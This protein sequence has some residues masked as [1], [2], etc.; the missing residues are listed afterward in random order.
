MKIIVEKS[1][2]P[3]W[4]DYALLHD[5]WPY[6][7]KNIR[8]AVPCG[9]TMLSYKHWL[10]LHETSVICRSPLWLDY[11][12]L[13][14]PAQDIKKNI[15]SQSL[16]IGLYSPTWQPGYKRKKS[17]CRSPFWLDY[18]LL[19]ADEKLEY[20]K[21]LSQSLLIGLYSPTVK[22]SWD[23]DLCDLSQSL[24]IGLYSPTKSEQPIIK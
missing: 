16:L 7:S 8:V 22:F 10:I 21:K 13:R 5:S 9:W 15:P 12:L 1:R 14:Y 4:L 3:L 6:L 23:T 24:L 18:P 2:S 17:L 11:A 19:H 20:W